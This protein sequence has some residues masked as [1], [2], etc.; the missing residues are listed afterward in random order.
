MDLRGRSLPDA[1]EAGGK[2]FLIETDFRA[3]LG[4][5]ECLKA[6]DGYA[7]LF[8]G[9]VPLPSQAVIDALDLFYMP[10]SEIPRGGPGQEPLAD[11]DIDADYIYAAFLQ[12]YGIDLLE[13]DM[14]WHKFLALFRALPGDTQMCRIME[15]RAYDGN[16][17]EQGRL[18]QAWA[19]PVRLTEEERQAVD[20]FNELFG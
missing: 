16:D 2:V 10:P 11:W 9:S 17:K 13:A 7:A 18:K 14:H 5:P 12:A 20:E 15:C 19:L 6:G 4:Y 1:I 3:W 8:A